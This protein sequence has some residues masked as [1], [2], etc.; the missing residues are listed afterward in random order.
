MR[1]TAEFSDCAPKGARRGAVPAFFVAKNARR[2][3]FAAVDSLAS[4]VKQA[5]QDAA[6]T[7]ATAP[8][9]LSCSR[10]DAV[11]RFGIGLPRAAPS[12][13]V[14]AIGST[15]RHR[16]WTALGVCSRRQTSLG[17]RSCEDRLQRSR[18]QLT[19]SSRACA[20]SG[21]GRARSSRRR[22]GSAARG[23]STRRGASRLYSAS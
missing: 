20:G 1:F 3:P 22:G 19:C 14:R 23:S 9:R 6:P 15:P 18:L 21:R 12:T 2:R 8:A 7:P 10:C 11:V 16:I 5:A 4:N 13:H 17:G